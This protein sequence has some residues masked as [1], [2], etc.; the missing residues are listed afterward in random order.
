MEFLYEASL[1]DLYDR[2]DPVIDLGEADLSE[3]DLD[4]AILT[5]AG[6]STVILRKADMYFA[7]LSGADLSWADMSE[8]YLREAFLIEADMC[9]AE[10]IE[11]DMRGADLTKAILTDAV[12]VTGEQLEQAKSLEGA[13]MPDRRVLKGEDNPDGLTFEEWLKTKGSG[14]NG[15]DDVDCEASTAS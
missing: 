9:E 8:A 14:E 7:T 11:A 2:E 6:L 15:Q 10:L 1:I 4:G 3:A 13:T 12:G 5:K